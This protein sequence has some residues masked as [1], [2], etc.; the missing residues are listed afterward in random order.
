[1]FLLSSIQSQTQACLIISYASNQ[2][3][4]G[5]KR[6]TLFPSSVCKAPFLS[7]T[8]IQLCN[9]AH[10]LVPFFMICAVKT[11]EATEET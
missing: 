10:G 1:M 5:L 11:E 3:C 7:Y 6:K 2:P 9:E 4:V 8:D